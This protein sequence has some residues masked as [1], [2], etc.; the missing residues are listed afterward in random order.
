MVLTF[1]YV[2]QLAP[3]VKK[4]I[5]HPRATDDLFVMVIE[6]TEKTNEDELKSLL[7]SVGAQEVNTQVAEE[8]WWIGRYDQEQE[9]YK[10]PNIA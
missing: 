3:F 4:H 2:C 8:G 1:C 6:C 9:L 10:E 7:T 5:F